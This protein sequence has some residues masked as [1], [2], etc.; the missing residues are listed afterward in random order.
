MK[1]LAA[2]VLSFL[3]VFG[4]LEATA[5]T[6][7]PTTLNWTI[8]SSVSNTGTSVVVATTASDLGGI[9]QII[10]SLDGVVKQTCV[11][12]AIGGAPF[13][14]N[15]TVSWT[16]TVGPHV[17]STTAITKSGMLQEASTTYPN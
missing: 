10:I 2:F 12:S 7:V 9:T 14:C 4:I 17:V 16:T 3:T 11:N 1:Y 8:T 15:T 13:G 5:Q 6:P